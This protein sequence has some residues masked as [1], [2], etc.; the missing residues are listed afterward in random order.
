M[1]EIKYSNSNLPCMQRFLRSSLKN[2]EEEG[3]SANRLD[4]LWFSAHPQKRMSQ[5]SLKLVTPVLLH[6]ACTVIENCWL[7]KRPLSIVYVWPAFPRMK[8]IFEFFF[9]LSGISMGCW[10]FLWKSLWK[11]CID[12]KKDWK[13][14]VIL[15]ILNAVMQRKIHSFIPSI[16]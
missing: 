1:Y 12:W 11:W 15:K 4:F 9:V 13:T 8:W 14:I 6:N 16:N 2:P 10:T 7:I 3:T 5:S